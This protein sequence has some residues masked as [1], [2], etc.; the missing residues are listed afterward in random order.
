M[1]EEEIRGPKRHC[2]K[3]CHKV[4]ARS[5]LNEVIRAQSLAIHGN[6]HARW[7]AVDAWD[8]ESHPELVTR[9]PQVPCMDS[10][11]EELFNPGN[12]CT[13]GFF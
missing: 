12:R 4:Y 6:L 13:R 1:R 3:Q 9:Y 8:L 5:R 7:I 10:R 2:A 11:P